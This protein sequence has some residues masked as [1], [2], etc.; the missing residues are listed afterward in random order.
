MNP[1]NLF[2]VKINEYI[3]YGISLIS[4]WLINAIFYFGGKMNNY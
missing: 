1:K 2:C 4:G 3:K